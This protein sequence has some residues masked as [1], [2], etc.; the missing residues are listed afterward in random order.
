MESEMKK[1][2]VWHIGEVRRG[3]LTSI[4]EIIGIISLDVQGV[5]LPH[6]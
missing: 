3:N 4:A 2:E 1:M 6:I 5:F